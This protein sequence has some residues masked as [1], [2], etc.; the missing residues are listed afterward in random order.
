MGFDMEKEDA[1]PKSKHEKGI[2]YMKTALLGILLFATG[3]FAGSELLP[4]SVRGE[5]VYQRAC[6][7]CHGDNGDGQGPAAKF[8]DP[9]PRDF[10]AGQYKFRS[11]PS[12]ELPTDADLI[13]IVEDGIPRTQMPGWKRLLTPQEIHDVVAY[14]KTFNADFQEFGAPE[15]I[16]VPTPPAASPALIEEGRMVYMVMECWAC[17][18]GSGKGNGASAKGLKDDAGNKILPWN[19]TNFRY[20]AGNDPHTL[21][22]TISTG[23]NGTPMPSFTGVFLFEGGQFDAAKYS[24]AYGEEDIQLLRAYFRAQPS[25]TAL[26][27]MTDEDR[28]HLEEK[29]KWALVHYVG[30]LPKKPNLFHRLFWADTEV[31]K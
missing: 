1:L 24:E 27:S 8:L 4:S 29:R 6:A 31:T 17:H 2:L 11:T 12:G 22:R 25:L 7:A 3:T 30:S 21:Y 18:G 23:L 19:L 26:E 15:A 5:G 13:R 20:K 9:L 10:I 28:K 16:T 14:L